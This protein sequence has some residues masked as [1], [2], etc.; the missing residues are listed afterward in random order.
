M[1]F[2]NETVFTVRYGLFLLRLMQ[3]NFLLQRVN[4]IFFMFF[5]SS[6]QMLEF[7]PKW[8]IIQFPIRTYVIGRC[9]T[10]TD[11]NKRTKKQNPDFENSPSPSSVFRLPSG[12]Q[13][14]LQSAS[15]SIFVVKWLANLAS[16]WT[17]QGQRLL[18]TT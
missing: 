8:F 13:I 18:A 16:F 11:S 7:K 17:V 4:R 10:S 14:L 9:K 1:V 15:P 6:R 2:I 3:V 12:S 5:K